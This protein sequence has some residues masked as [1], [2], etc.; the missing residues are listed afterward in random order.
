[1]GGAAPRRGGPRQPRPSARTSARLRRA[2]ALVV[3]WQDGR[4]TFENY[5]TRSVVSAEPSAI[6]ILGFFEEW[7]DPAELTA[8]LPDF[9]PASVRRA[10]DTL[11]RHALLLREGTPAAERDE[12]LAAAWRH[13]LP[14]AGF[15]FAT[16]DTRFASLRSWRRLARSFLEESPQPPVVKTYP[17][18]RRISLP[19]AVEAASELPRVLLARRTEREFSGEAVPLEKI[20][21]LLRYTWGATGELDSPIFGKLLLKTS[22]S[23]GA[24]HPIEVY[25]VAHDVAGLAP[26]IYHYDVR[27]HALAQLRRGRLRKRFEELAVGQ[28]HVG[29]AAALFLMTAVWPRSMWKYRSPRTYRVVTLDAGHLGQTFCLVATW[30][31]LAPFTTAALRDSE[32]EE[33]LGIDGIGESVLYLAGVGVPRARRAVRKVS[34]GADGRPRGGATNRQRPPR[35]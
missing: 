21:T 4:L 3:H 20:A 17:G 19:A 13:W 23:G 32:I 28:R 24:R 26:G 14:Q 5:L 22:P 7:R 18:R 9:R 29:R 30:L 35:G 16:R 8:A 6:G 25:L 31:G 12:L 10:V 2:R 15:H 1:M 27:A 33:A 11:R 34:P